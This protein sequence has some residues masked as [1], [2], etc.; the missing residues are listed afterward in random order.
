MH[1]ISEY[2]LIIDF[3]GPLIHPHPLPYFGTLPSFMKHDFVLF[4]HG[5][6]SNLSIWYGYDSVWPKQ[7]TNFLM[8]HTLYIKNQV[9]LMKSMVLVICN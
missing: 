6:I 5:I 3:Y 2:S 9:L 4:I 1:Y 7:C 8:Y